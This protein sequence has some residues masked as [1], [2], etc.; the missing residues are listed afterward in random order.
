MSIGTWEPEKRNQIDLDKLKRLLDSF[1]NVELENLP[2][3]L[4]AEVIESDKWLMKCQAKDWKAAEELNDDQLVLLIRFFTLAERQL[5]GW[6]GGKLCPVIYLVK[7]L[8]QRSAFDAELRQW[9]KSNTDNRYLPN[10]A[11]L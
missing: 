2:D 4:P 11:A 6:D 3:S 9:I 1:A 8:K 10:G 7:I 5:P